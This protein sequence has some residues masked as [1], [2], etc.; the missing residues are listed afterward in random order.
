LFLLLVL[1]AAGWFGWRAAALR[2]V[3]AAP[4]AAEETGTSSWPQPPASVEPLPMV[5]DEPHDPPPVAQQPDPRFF[6]SWKDQFYGA[7][8]MTFRE[9]GT[10]VMVILP[11]AVFRTLYGD[12]LTF[13]FAWTWDG[14]AVHMAMTGGEPKDATETLSQLFGKTSDKR[15]ERLDESELHLRS[16]DTQKLYIHRRE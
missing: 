2:P 7:R 11:D 9:D 1:C 13:H 10:G 4:T 8:T 16:L 15:I 12:K 6:G 3:P 5:A 14:D